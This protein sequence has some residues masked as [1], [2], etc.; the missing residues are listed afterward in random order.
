MTTIR[1]RDTAFGSLRAD[2]AELV[3]YAPLLRQMF[4]RDWLN[5]YRSSTSAVALSMVAPLIQVLVMTFA[6]EFVLNAGPR[7]LSVYI[8]CATIPFGFFQTSI[9]SAFTG[10]DVIQPL[11]KRMYFPREVFVISYVTINFVQMLL[12]LL[13]FLVYRYAIMP[14]FLPWPGPPPMEVLWLPV[15]MLLAYMLTLG[16]ALFTSALF[17]YFEDVR[18][19]I[20]VVLSLMF[21]LVPIL[22]YPENIFYS[23]KIA[24]PWLRSAIYHVYLANPLAWIVDAFK[25]IFFG[26]Q[27]ISQR[28]HSHLLSAPFDYRYFAINTILSCLV[29]IGGYLFFNQ[30]KWKFAERP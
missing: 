5:R 9:M 23:H 24:S 7:N 8:L 29:L 17:F 28:G 14:L 11:V 12:S 19:M 20:N 13:V 30:M 15:L 10:I 18:F 3:A 2:L 16:T 25:Q 6:V 22:Y 1:P 4:I 21:Y 27:I 26:Q